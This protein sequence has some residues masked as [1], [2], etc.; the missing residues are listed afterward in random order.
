MHLLYLDGRPGLFTGNEINANPFS[1]TLIETLVD[2]LYATCK[3]KSTEEGFSFEMEV[4]IAL[5]V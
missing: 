2:Q 4:K 3:F 1:L 5:G